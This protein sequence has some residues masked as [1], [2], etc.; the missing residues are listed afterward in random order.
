MTWE[1]N[2]NCGILFELENYKFVQIIK[3][4]KMFLMSQAN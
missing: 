3:D 2:I 4:K 1:S